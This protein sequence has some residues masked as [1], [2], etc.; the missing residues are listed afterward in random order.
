MQLGGGKFEINIS[1]PLVLEY[2]DVAK[3]LLGEIALNEE[4]INTVINYICAV[5]ERRKI[6]YLWRPVLRDPKDE[7]LLELAVAGGCDY[8]VTHNTAD[9]ADIEK[10]GIEVVKPA[11]FL[12]KI[13]EAE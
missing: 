13:G 8:I 12:K 7:M 3:R 11:E 5:G 2:E 6:F 1:V 10:F 9:F 4:D